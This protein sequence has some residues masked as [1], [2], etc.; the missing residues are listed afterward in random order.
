MSFQAVTIQQTNIYFFVFILLV[1]KS[2]LFPQQATNHTSSC[3]SISS[4]VIDGVLCGANR[5]PPVVKMWVKV[6]WRYKRLVL[7]KPRERIPFRL[8]TATVRWRRRSAY[9]LGDRKCAWCVGPTCAI[10]DSNKQKTRETNISC[11]NGI[12]DT[13]WLR[14]CFKRVKIP[15]L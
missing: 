15:E 1:L 2:G 12:K 7:S 14:F 4:V 11:E 6:Q 5:F 10:H 8:G 13:V 9:S 3:Q